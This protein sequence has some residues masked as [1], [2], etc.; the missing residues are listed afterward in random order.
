MTYQFPETTSNLD[1]I[2][3]NISNG[4]AV[5][6]LQ[7]W[8]EES[9]QILNAE[10]TLS[11]VQEWWDTN[12]LGLYLDLVETNDRYSEYS[13]RIGS[14]YLQN[15]SIALIKDIEGI[16]TYKFI[17]AVSGLNLVLEQGAIKI[18]NTNPTISPNRTV[19]SSSN[20]TRSGYVFLNNISN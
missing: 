8:S 17:E 6:T 5:A 4:P 20:E 19:Y 18:K 10:T 13:I 2:T 12:N 15:T 9:N 3:F 1:T 16:Y 14:P 7:L 11:G